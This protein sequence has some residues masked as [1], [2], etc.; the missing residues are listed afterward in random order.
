MNGFDPRRLLEALEG[1]G[2]RFVIIGGVAAVALGS[3][4][5]TLDLD[6]CY[7]RA[8]DNLD[9]LAAALEE[10]SATLRGAPAEVPFQRDAEALARGDHFT[11]DTSAGPFD[12]MALPAGSNGYQELLANSVEVMIKGVSVRV[13]SIDDLIR[14]KRAAGRP[15]DRIELEILGALREEIE[16]RAD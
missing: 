8:P 1:H 11:F 2:V 12:V 14:M 6:V 3:P 15:K 13:A 10:L 5:I 4:S 9:R 16:R 7:D